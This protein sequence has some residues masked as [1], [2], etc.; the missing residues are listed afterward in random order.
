MTNP[1]L[2]RMTPDSAVIAYVDYVTGLDNLIT[3]I[4]GRQF[5][6][7]I[8]A[9]AKFSG[10]FGLPTAV[11]GEENA[12]YGTF[13]PEI[14]ALIDAGAATFPRTTPSGATPAFMEWLRATGRRDVIIGG[15]SIDNCTLHTALD[16]LRA[17]FNVQVVTDVSG[18]NSKLAEDMAIQR[19][20][21]AGAVN[22][23]WL[24]TLTE[25]G[26]DFA[27]PHGAGMMGII[28][29]HW[30]ASTVGTVE[31]TTPDGHG[32]QLPAE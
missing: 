10:L 6:N 1:A 24:N 15:I 5:R 28:Q 14:R 13:L 32:M 20:A 4:P 19:L 3:T 26:T 18:S 30:P 16:L 25:L 22:A 27:G 12:Y 9:F 7:N 21:A 2:R 31:D 8:A 29:Q 23:G 17:G 11:F